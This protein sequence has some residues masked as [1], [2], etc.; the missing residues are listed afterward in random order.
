MSLEGPSWTF[1]L[2]WDFKATRERAED[3]V[4]G[5]SCLCIFYSVGLPKRPWVF[6]NPHYSHE[7]VPS[8]LSKGWQMVTLMWQAQALPTALICTV[9]SWDTPGI[10]PRHWKG[11]VR[12]HSLQTWVTVPLQ[13]AQFVHTQPY[14]HSLETWRVSSPTFCRK[15]FFSPPN[16]HVQ[17]RKCK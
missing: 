10:R 16:I 6:C 1:Q 14:K 13:N 15:L 7:I 17:Y 4:S 11:L 12:K 5:A 8:L 3:G 2:W 9:S